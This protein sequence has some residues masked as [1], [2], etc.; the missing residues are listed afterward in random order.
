[1]RLFSFAGFG[2][3]LAALVLVVFG[4]YDNYPKKHARPLHKSELAIMKLKE[5]AAQQASVG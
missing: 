1:L 5:S 3:A 4:A 2:L